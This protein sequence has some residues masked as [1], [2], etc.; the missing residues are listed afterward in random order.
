MS[1]AQQPLTGD[2][3]VGLSDE[4]RWG[5]VLVRVVW[6]AILLG[7]AMETLLLLLA[8]GFEILP[9]FGSAITDLMGKVSWS[10][11]VCAG[12]AVGTALSKARTSLMGLMGLLAA[13]LAFNVSRALQQGLANTL[14]AAAAG[15]SVGSQ[16][17][18]LLA[19]IKAVEYGCLGVAVGWLGRRPW[20]G[21]LTHAAAG[22]AVGIVFG[23]TIVG[24]TYL[25]TPELLSTADLLSRGIN[26][27]IFP[28]GCALVL[29]TA[30]AFGE[31]VGRR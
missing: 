22:L 16:T 24:F 11:L 12:L 26:E 9:S 5:S 18:I 1:R 23:G 27:I 25:S 30:T 6:L 29:Y 3:S 14:E 10:A 13:P 28:V 4:A 20:G 15:A 21:V 19:I 8:A 31:R 2:S 7:L 17:L